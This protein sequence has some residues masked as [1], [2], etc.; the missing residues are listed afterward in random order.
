MVVNLWWALYKPGTVLSIISLDPPTIL[1][2]SM[3]KALISQVRKQMLR[4]HL[5]CPRSHKHKARESESR[6]HI[7]TTITSLPL[8]IGG[9]SL[10]RWNCYHCY[11]LSLIPSWPF[12]HQGRYKIT[13][14]YI[15]PVSL[16]PGHKA[17]LVRLGKEVLHLSNRRNTIYQTWLG[18][19]FQ[20]LH[21]RGAAEMSP[22]LNWGLEN[23]RKQYCEI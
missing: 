16:R 6:V 9:T 12:L 22:E 4:G 18:T 13:S 23:E 5:P 21:R 7:L 8:C 15:P 10:I 19:C 14:A 17:L 3:A 11:H 20:T 1:Q 2:G